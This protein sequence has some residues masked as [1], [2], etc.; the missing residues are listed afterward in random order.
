MNNPK[1]CF[2][3]DDDHEEQEIFEY[4]LKSVNPTVLIVTASNGIDALQKLVT[5]KDFNPDFIFL[6]LNMPRMDGKETLKELRKIDRLN[7]IPVVIYST[8]GSERDIRETQ[9]LG[10]NFYLE[11]QGN[12][13]ILKKRLADFFST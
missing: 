13:T 9:A 2:L 12:L 7:L 8:S 1:T 4:A 11:K 6:D 3:I 5:E 10:A